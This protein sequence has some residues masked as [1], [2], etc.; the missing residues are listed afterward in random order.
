MEVLY[1]HSR[2]S[3]SVIQSFSNDPPVTEWVQPS[4]P[5]R[6]MSWVCA[7]G[8]SRL[9]LSPV[10]PAVVS[11][12][13]LWH[14]IREC[15]VAPLCQLRQREHGEC[16]GPALRGGGLCWGQ[17]ARGKALSPSECH[18]SGTSSPPCASWHSFDCTLHD[19]VIRLGLIFKV[20]LKC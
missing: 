1:F 10:F 18:Q 6:I 15:R 17:Q 16:R 20:L 2:T 9:L 13:P 4:A 19:S 7:L 3:P 14:H 5:G 11:T 12:G 8:W